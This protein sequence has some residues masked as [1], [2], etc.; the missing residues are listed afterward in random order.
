VCVVVQASHPRLCMLM[1]VFKRRPPRAS[2]PVA[3]ACTP[4]TVLF[5]AWTG[6]LPL[7]LQSQQ[8][9]L[10]VQPAVQIEQ[11]RVLPA[12]WQLLTCKTCVM[13]LYAETALHLTHLP[14]LVACALQCGIDF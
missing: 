1:G 10:L 11:S 13:S 12:P 14:R 5:M 4:C 7:A 6:S 8:P 2:T 3:C 9:W